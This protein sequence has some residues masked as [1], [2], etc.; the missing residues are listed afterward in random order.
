MNKNL[1]EL[2][3]KTPGV[4]GT[5]DK[6]RQVISENISCDDI[7]QDGAGNL[8]CT[9]FSDKENAPTVVLDAHMD[10]VGFCVKEILPNGFLKISPV[11]G[12]DER[13]L[14]N[15]SV[16]IH[17][18]NDVFG[19]IATKPPHLMDAKDRAEVVSIEK[20]FVDT[21]DNAD[22]IS[23][24]DRISYYPSVCELLNQVSATYLDNRLGVLAIIEVFESLKDKSLPFNLTALFSVGEEYGLKGALASDIKADLLVVLDVTFGKTPDETSDEALDVGGGVAIGIGPNLD[25]KIAEKFIEIGREKGIKTQTEVLEYTGTN[26]WVYQTMGLGISCAMLSVP[27]KYMHTPTE[28]VRVSDYDSCVELLK[29]FLSETEISHSEVEIC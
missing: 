17:G 14:P 3:C 22:G 16:M 15:L 27:I 20:S 9:K 25:K 4:S 13:I 18:K 12:I 7:K 24:G 6:I 19:V 29:A 2:L 28:T 5:E 1:L 11:G 10:C 23:I 8:L 21:G 26:A